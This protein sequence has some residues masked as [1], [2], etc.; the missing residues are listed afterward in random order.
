M[1]TVTDAQKHDLQELTEKAIASV[2]QAT[3]DLV[4]WADLVRDPEMPWAFRWSNEAVR[5]ANV[6]ATSYIL[7]AAK[8][9]GVLDRVLSAG[10]K[11]KGA[12][13]INS[14]EVGDNIY[15]D[16]ELVG[17]KPPAWKDER[18]NWPPDGAHKEAINQYA[19]GC[20]PFYT[21]EPVDQLTGPPPPA[22]PQKGDPDVLDWIKSVE[23]NWSWIGRITRRL[24]NWYYEGAVPK[25]QLMEC[26]DYVYSRQD[27]ETGF[28][29]NGIQTTFKALITI[30]DTTELPVPRAD[31][32][33]DTVLRVMDAPTY[34]DN[35]FPC[36]EFDAFYDIAIAWSCVP[37]H[38][39][40]EVK[41]LAA[42]RTSY[43]L[44]SHRQADSGLSSYV[45]RC[46][47]T[48]LDFDMAPA[49]AQGD[50]FGWGIYTSGIN[51][52]L[53]MLGVADRVSWTGTWRQREGRDTSVFVDVGREIAE[54]R[55]QV[56]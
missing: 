37:G 8:K 33:V 27:P 11:A 20:L 5:G 23:P 53:D 28:W 44:D 41:K 31:K 12:E 26:M 6:A 36:E 55:G 51:I 7:G 21:A 50:A 29:A 48:W 1:G 16:P 56:E 9:C 35:L 52:C 30:F 43:I 15:T 3:E 34:D 45:D 19:R 10:Q 39:E 38:R 32:I 49:K 25:E 47:P 14:L 17:R 46:I 40:E 42:Y 13:W 4:T 24:I 18:E 2:N 54:W 22:W